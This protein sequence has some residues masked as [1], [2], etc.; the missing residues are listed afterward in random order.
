MIVDIA[1]AIASVILLCYSMAV[2]PDHAECWPGWYVA[3]LRPS[4]V[5]TCMRVPCGDPLYDGAG[6]FPDRT[7]DLSGEIRGRIYCTGG[8][9]PIVVLARRDADARV[10]GCT[11]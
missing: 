6:G 8:S 4:G 2:E 7:V 5:Y 9:H 10:V 3:N 1:C 11:R